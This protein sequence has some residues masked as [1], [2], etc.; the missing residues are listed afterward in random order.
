MDQEV[1]RPAATGDGKARLVTTRSPLRLDGDVLRN[2][3]GA[4]RLGEHSM[5]IEREFGLRDGPDEGRAP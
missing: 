2:D 1:A 4:P 3:R 5:P